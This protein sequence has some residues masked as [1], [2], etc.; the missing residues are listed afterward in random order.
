MKIWK[1]RDGKRITGKE[2][3]KRWG[4]G[5]EGVTPNQKMKTQLIGNKIMLL[6]YFLGLCMA[7]YGYKTLWWLG[8]ILLGGT[9]NTTIQY[10][11]IKQQVI[12]FKKIEDSLEEDESMKGG[13]QP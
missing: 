8:V 3:I 9:I 2:F 12:M 6:G 11:N 4:E 1:D 7:I 13:K 5:I 10:I